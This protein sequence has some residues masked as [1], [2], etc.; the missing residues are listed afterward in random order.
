MS[1]TASMPRAICSP[2]FDGGLPFSCMRGWL[3][4]CMPANCSVNIQH[5]SLSG[6]GSPLMEKQSS[7]PLG[8]EAFTTCSRRPPELPIGEP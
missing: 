8:K 3:G 6:P 5:P 4:A 2:S 7:P 1:G